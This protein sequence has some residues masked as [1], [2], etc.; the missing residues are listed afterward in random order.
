[1]KALLYAAI[2]NS[3]AALPIIVFVLILANK[4]ELMGSYKNGFLSNFF[5]AITLAMMFLSAILVTWFF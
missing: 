3:I 5:G 4:K 1:M 2:V